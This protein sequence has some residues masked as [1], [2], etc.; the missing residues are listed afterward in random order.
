MIVGAGHNGLVCG[1]YL[2]RAGL[3]V[4]I[5]ERREIIGGTTVT[6]EIWPGYKV[7][8]ASYIMGLLQPKIILD[9]E[10]KKYGFEVLTPSPIFHPLHNGQHVFLWDDERRTAK[11]L[12]KLSAKDGAAFLEYRAHLRNIIPIMQRILWEIPP[13]PGSSNMVDIKNLVRFAWRFRDIGSR[14]YEIYDLLTMSAYDYLGRWFES[15]AVKLVLAFNAG[16]AGCAN[17]SPKTPGTA[18]VL[19]RP[20]LRDGTTEAGGFG[21]VKGGMG[22]ITQAIARS[23]QRFGLK[24]RTDANVQSII[25][26]GG[27]ACGVALAS[28]EEIMGRV[29]VANASAQTTFLKLLAPNELPGDFVRSVKNIRSESTVFKINLGVDQLPSYLG[30]DSREAGFAYPTTVRIGPSLEY[31]ERACEDSRS[32]RFSRRPT[33]MI[34]APTALDNTI[35]PAGKHILNIFGTHTPYQLR[36]GG[37]DQQREAFY[38]TFLETASEFAPGFDKGIVHSQVLLPPDLERIFELPRGNIHHAEIS[39]DQVFFRRPVPGYA[40]YRSPVRALYQCGASTHPGG[41]V[42]GVPGHNAAKIILRDWKRRGWH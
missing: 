29:V 30:F 28:G 24:I 35:A 33:M 3:N 5:L 20:L 7:S 42:T 6:E 34:L 14:F 12:S 27:R 18:Y 38:N 9:L 10:L 41:G 19:T 21:F 13:D 32:G 37:W 1:W 17:S 11:E 15:D 16:A 26:K 40:D 22:A 39:P 25:T 4:C 36:E 23:A 8:T 2:A 31:M